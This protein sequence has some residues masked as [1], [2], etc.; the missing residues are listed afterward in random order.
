MRYLTIFKK[1]K[2]RVDIL[3]IFLAIFITSISIIIYYSHT[4]SSEAIL[5]LGNTLIEQAD[6]T[7][8]AKL[9]EFLTPESMID[10]VDFVMTDG[11]LDVNDLESLTDV[12][13]IVLN[14]NPQLINVY[15][16]D[17]YGTVFLENRYDPNN[18]MYRK[19]IPFIENRDIPNNTAFISE[20]VTNKNNQSTAELIYKEKAGKIIK[21]E[22]VAVNYDPRTRPW[23]SGAQNSSKKHWIG[24]YEFFQ[25]KK[26][27]ITVSY[28][29]ME[30]NQFRGVAAED[31]SIDK[32]NDELKKRS[33]SNRGDIYLISS[34]GQIIGYEKQLKNDIADINQ[35]SD[36]A[37]RTAYTMHQQLKKNSFIF[38][39]D[40]TKYIAHFTPY[41]IT[42]SE[43]WEI[44]TILPVDV[45]VSTL[46]HAKQMVLIFSVIMLLLGFILIYISSHKI[47][48]PIIRLAHE[49]REMIKLK[50]DRKSDVITHIYE[51]QMMI[52][53]LNATRNALFAF[54]KYVPKTLVEQL[55]RSEL[56]AQVGGAKKEITILFSDIANFTEL[57]EDTDPEQLMIHLSSY[58][59]ALTKI[60]QHNKGNIDKYIGDSIMAFWGAPLNDLDHVLHACRA[61]LACQ[62][63]VRRLNNKWQAEGKLVFKTR[64][65]LNTGT[66]IVGNMGSTDR[67]NY[68]V[69]GDAV[70]IA[71][72]LEKL[73]KEY[74]VDIIVSQ[75][76]HEKVASRFLFRPLDTLLIRGKHKPIT[77][78]QL[79]GGLGDDEATPLEIELC[80]LSTEGFNAY[81][82]NDFAK[83]TDI[84]QKMV[85]KFP[86]DLMAEIYL[87]R[88]KS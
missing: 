51:V 25:S 33:I 23:Y 17:L 69:L 39:Q 58:L 2:L 30:N 62:R 31:I 55:L 29:I 35:V 13:H 24:I 71:S 46:N 68:T 64:F 37:L 56:I 67:L 4:R 14:S 47:S 50:F 54:A 60:I 61:V 85:D 9:N 27:G 52:E 3:T 18:P 34:N 41:S 7:I 70:N 5:N 66:A 32:I 26:H 87:K 65:G 42:P 88:M 59:N 49:T 22:T 36:S 86:D 79:V 76:V 21:K 38:V 77:I 84:F 20:I 11:I 10:T 15:V 73:G 45:F 74:G 8:I 78:Y 48:R 43:Q 40:H 19:F 28:P 44:V 63:E 83:A 72:R 1:R 82:K 80:E 53:A 16:A 12:M 75:Y 57:A 6:Q 81:S